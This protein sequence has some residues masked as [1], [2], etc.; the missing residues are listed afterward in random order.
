MKLERLKYHKMTDAQNNAKKVMEQAGEDIQGMIVG[1][2]RDHVDETYEEQREEAKEKAEEKEQQ[3]EKIEL[4]KEQK[5]LLEARIE[6]AR[7]DS[8]RAEAAQ[9]KQERDA[10]EEAELLSDMADAGMNVAGANDAVKA[11]IKD[12]LN[13]LKLVEAD[14]KGIEVNEEL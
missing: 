1:E 5:E 4:R 13:K 9:K 11:E 6:E 10:R 3:E 2:A 7:E 14:I 12:M 8:N